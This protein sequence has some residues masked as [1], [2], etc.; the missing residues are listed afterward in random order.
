MNRRARLS[1]LMN[2]ESGMLSIALR[3]D[4]REEIVKWYVSELSCSEVKKTKLR[5]IFTKYGIAVAHICS[6]HAPQGV[7]FFVLVDS[8][9]RHKGR[10]KMKGQT[11]NIL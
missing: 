11:T 6:I 7:I 8:G 9:K 1:L 5:F 2:L 4:Q 3:L 10:W